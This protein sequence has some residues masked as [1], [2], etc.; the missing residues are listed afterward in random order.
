MIL[1]IICYFYN[2]KSDNM[3]YKLKDTLTS[4]F[5]IVIV[6]LGLSLL[7]LTPLAS[8][9]LLG[10]IFAYLIRPISRRLEPT[11]KYKSV[12]VF[13][14][15]VLI[16]IPMIALLAVLINGIIQTIPSIT[17]F[18]NSLHL[19]SLNST[20][21][22]NYPLIKHNVPPGFY[23]YLDSSIGTVNVEIT[24]I[25]RSVLDYILNLLK[26]VPFIL[27]Q[28]FIFIASTFYFARDG[29]KLWEYVDYL[30]PSKRHHYFNRLFKEADKV[31]KSIFVGH[32]MTGILTGI[33]AGV[34]FFLLGYPY[35]VLFGILTGFFQLIPFIGHW[36]IPIVLSLY[37][38]LSGNYLR[39]VAVLVLAA[40]LSI[41]DFYIRPYLSGRYADIHPLIFMLGFISGPLI[42]GIVGFIIGPLILGVTYAAV[43]AYKKEEEERMIEESSSEDGKDSTIKIEST[44]TEEN[45]DSTV[46][47]G[48]NRK[49]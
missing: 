41:F 38:V 5:F 43:I 2:K 28:L 35:A 49:Q 31:L 20:S 12:A 18:V 22:Q 15:M 48:N 39:A 21:I 23:P 47:K 27:L 34:G 25:L 1:I 16:I 40:A 24:N 44:K 42:F 13:V 37:D 26:S 17:Q 10:A 9:I 32:F 19:T 33:L 6:L 45:D 36:P 7:V 3:Y 30:I 14:G 29:D 46:E 11:V 4:A 8:M